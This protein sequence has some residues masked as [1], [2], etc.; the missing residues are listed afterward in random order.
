MKRS[1]A[2]LIGSF[3]LGGGGLELAVL[4][5]AVATGPIWVPIEYGVGQ[6]NIK[7]PV[8]VVAQNDKILT[9]AFAA[10]REVSLVVQKNAVVRTFSPGM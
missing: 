5:T 3:L 6:S 7:Q 2:P 10:E 8:E 9:L 4:G 1:I